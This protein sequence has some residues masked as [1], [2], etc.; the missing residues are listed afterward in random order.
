MIPIASPDIGD[1]EKNAVLDVLDSGVIAAGP[2]VKEFEERF[3]DY[4]GVEHA[5]AVSSGTAALHVA[6]LAHGIGSGDEVI[7]SPFTFIASANSVLFT[8]ARPVFAD[9]DETYNLDPGRVAEQIT[10]ET[11]AI[12]PVHLYGQPAEM[13]ALTEL[14]VD[15]DLI[16]IEDA[17]QAHGAEYDGRKVGSFGCGC[18]SFYPTKNMTSAEGGM[19][20]THDSEVDERAR[21]IRQHGMKRRYYHEML[22]YNLR[23]TDVH[24]A[25]GVEQLKK[26]DQYNE[27][28]ITN[29]LYLSKKITNKDFNLPIL[30]GNCRH[31]FH[32]YTVRH[33]DRET[34]VEALKEN[35]IGYGIYYPVPVHKQPYYVG[36]GYDADCPVAEQVADEVVSLPIHPKV[37]EDDLGFIAGVLNRL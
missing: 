16:V 17:C 35:D 14:A 21:A 12:M 9:I 37:S 30:C 10:K 28:R 29:A 8:G 33:P 18:F 25:I 4:I 6:L 22:G 11:K 24:A 20:T 5:V 23:M 13:K 2:K 19:I 36:L 27:R 31:V 32:Q 34:V 26:L 15:H 1:E 7:T 3:A